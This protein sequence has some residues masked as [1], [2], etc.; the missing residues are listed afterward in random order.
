MFTG[1]CLVQN[2]S[3][4]ESFCVRV[5]YRNQGKAEV[6]TDFFFFTSGNT[7]FFSLIFNVYSICSGRANLGHFIYVPGDGSA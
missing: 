7:L 5:I 3:T 1:M 4:E 2:G 6:R